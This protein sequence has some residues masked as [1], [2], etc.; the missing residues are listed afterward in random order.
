MCGVNGSPGVVGQGNNDGG[1]T[2]Y[3]VYPCYNKTLGM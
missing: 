2:P 3:E 1:G